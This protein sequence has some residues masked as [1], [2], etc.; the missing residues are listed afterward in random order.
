[1]FRL[2]LICLTNSGISAARIDQGQADDRQHPGGAAV[3]GPGTSSLNSL[4]Q[5]TSTT[6]IA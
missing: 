5:A 1:M 6:E 4:C 3:A 2:D